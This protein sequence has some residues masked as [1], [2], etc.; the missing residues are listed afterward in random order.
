MTVE[1]G[2]ADT[3]RDFFLFNQFKQN[4]NTFNLNRRIKETVYRIKVKLN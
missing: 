1:N 3:L 4:I 2:G